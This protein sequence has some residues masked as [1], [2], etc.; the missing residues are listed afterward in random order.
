MIITSTETDKIYTALSSAQY[1]FPIIPK[2]KEVVKRGLSKSG[3]PFEYSYR[4]SS[5]ET[6]IEKIKEPL[7]SNGLSFVQSI[8]RSDRHGV[9]ITRLLHLSGQYIE[10]SFPLVF[11]EDDMQHYGGV[12]T[13]GKRYAL[14]NTLGLANDE[15]MDANELKN[16]DFSVKRPQAHASRSPS[17]TV[18]KQQTAQPAADKRE[19]QHDAPSTT[20]AEVNLPPAK[21]NAGSYAI[22]EK[23]ANRLYAIAKSKKWSVALAQSYVLLYYKKSVAQLNRK[24][25]DLVCEYFEN[26]VCDDVVA[27][28]LE[29]VA[30]SK[31]TWEP[32]KKG[33]AVEQLNK[34]KG[35]YVDHTAPPPFPSSD[36][37]PF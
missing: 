5:Y 30:A 6:I 26:T 23:Q 36:E 28:S 8:V 35:G 2:D 21:H 32:S 31:G 1:N 4:Y 29:N 17:V 14:T 16:D 11:N 20:A 19:I 10:T 18:Q 37:I 24:E 13:Y 15:D 12:S 33:S 25:Y 3:K 34:M 7:K 9:C 27:S 22:S